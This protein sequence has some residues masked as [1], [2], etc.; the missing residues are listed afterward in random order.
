MFSA[1]IEG[2]HLICLADGYK[3]DELKRIRK[4]HVFYC[5]ACR[6]QLD[7]K[8]GD[9][10][11]HHFAHKPDSVCPVPHEPESRYHLKGKQLLYEWFKKEG[12]SP[13]VEP[14]LKQIRQRPDLLVDGGERKI[15]VEFQCANLN[16]TEYRQR[17]AGFLSL[18]IDPFW[19]IGGNRLKRLS[20]GFFQLS[21]FHWQFSKGDVMPPR[22]VF[23]CPDQKAFL[24]L[25]HLIPFLTNKTSASMRFLPLQQTKLYGLI[26]LKSRSP[27]QFN[28]WKR[29][30]LSFRTIPRRFLSKESKQIAALFYERF[31]IPLPLFPSEVFLPVSSGYIFVQPVYV[32]QG[33]LYLF[34]M[35]RPS[36]RLQSAVAYTNQLIR[37]NRLKLR[38]N[39]REKAA[40][41]V[42]EYVRLL[43]EK[44]FFIKEKDVY[45]PRWPAPAEQ[46]LEELLKRDARYFSE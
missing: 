24:I 28:G 30:V 27:L 39:K 25:E 13:V 12:L 22:L 17:S 3:A 4:E 1:M 36:F 21:G 37:S 11:L 6:Q 40:D 9:I 32:W 29:N 34:F 5:P 14:Y 20:N 7:L 15:A 8:V 23:F 18:G 44:G 31:H 46:R 43:H 19:I 41:A 42:G 26:S 2:G 45:F 35:K 16:N 10:R 38:W 33:Y